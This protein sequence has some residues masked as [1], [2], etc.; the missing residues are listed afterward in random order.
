[1]WNIGILYFYCLAFNYFQ[2]LLQAEAGV[3]SFLIRNGDG[4]VGGGGGDIPR[5]KTRASVKIMLHNRL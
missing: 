5:F 1:M 3:Q 2:F 4:Q